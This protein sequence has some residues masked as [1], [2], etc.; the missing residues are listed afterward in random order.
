MKRGADKIAESGNKQDD[1]ET[2]AMPLK[3]YFRSRA[4]CNPLSHNDGFK[5]PVS[6]EQAN[7]EVHYPNI[8]ASSRIVRFVDVGMGFGGL[9]VA[10]AEL[11]PDKLVLGMEIRAKVSRYSCSIISADG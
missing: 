5:Y 3:R 7:W 6:P 8:E 1:A 2:A 4:H 9:T 11:F 10:L